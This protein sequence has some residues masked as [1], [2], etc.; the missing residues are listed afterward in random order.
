MLPRK[1]NLLTSSA[2]SSAIDRLLGKIY[3]PLLCLLCLFS[4]IHYLRVSSLLA[5]V[6]SGWA[7]G[8]WTI[9]Y[10]TGA[11][12]RG[13]SGTIILFF[14]RTFHLKINWLVFSLQGIALISFIGLFLNLVRKKALTFWYVIACFSPGFFLLFTYYDSMAIGRKEILL[15]L[16]FTAWVSICNQGKATTFKVIIFSAI[17]FFLTLVHEAFVFYSLYFCAAMW[18]THSS[19]GSKLSFAIPISSFA[20]AAVTF[21]YFKTVDPITS[22]IGLLELGALPEVCTGIISSGSQDAML[23]IKQYFRDFD[24]LALLNLCLVFTII[25]LPVYLI[26]HSVVL[27]LGNKRRWLICVFLLIVFSFPLFIFAIDWGRWISIHVTLSVLMLVLVLNDKVE[28]SADVQNP[29]SLI[30]M[31]LTCIIASVYFISFTLTFSVGHCCTRDFFRSLG[32]LDKIQ[33]IGIFQ[34]KADR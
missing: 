16:T 1:I 10:D 23:L 21:F 18:L 7:I 25:L 31:A 32:P 12:R 8:D 3:L 17:Y 30:Q 27:S 19:Q 29:I 6:W 15:F 13:L 33:H 26:T 20:A 14:A 22:C 2:G 24:E 4:V 5:E 28:K 34:H 9:N 11:T